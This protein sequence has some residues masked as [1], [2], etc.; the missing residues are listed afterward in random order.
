[1]EAYTAY[2][3]YI[4]RWSIDKG[5]YT[6]EV[7]IPDKLEGYASGNLWFD[8]ELTLFAL[9]SDRENTYRSN[10]DI[11]VDNKNHLYSIARKGS[12]CGSTYFGTLSHIEYLLRQGTWHDELTELGKQIMKAWKEARR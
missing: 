8:K 12:G 11:Y 5:D 1:M 3:G 10:W 6:T 4:P 9:G 2:R 7:S